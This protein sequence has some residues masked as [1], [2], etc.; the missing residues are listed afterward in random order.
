MSDAN[1]QNDGQYDA[2]LRRAERVLTERLGE[3]VRLGDVQQMSERRRR[4]LLLRCRV[5]DGPLAGPRS[6]I[7]K[8]ARQRR[9]DP[10]D[11]KSRPAV[12]LFRD[13][14]GLEFLNSLGDPHLAIPKFYG[15]DRQAGFFLMED[16]GGSEDLDHVLTCGSAKRARHALH[17]LATALGRMHAVTAG[18]VD[19]YQ[20]MRDALGP[21]D[22]MHRKRLAEHARDYGPYLAE[23]CAR[24][25]VEV[26]SGF[27]DDVERVALAMAEPG[28][29]LTYTH[30]DACP[31][32]SVLV[33]DSI[34]LID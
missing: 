14:A 30:A 24:L 13:W 1:T 11:P 7:L 5:L 10:E 6:V 17:L 3:T 16:F 15:G 9:Y 8:R 29:F 32:N 23:E 4:N 31:D 33:G 19:Q 2:L 22:G 28:D 25:G 21:G 12:G 20:K 27:F 26:A 18:R 34:C